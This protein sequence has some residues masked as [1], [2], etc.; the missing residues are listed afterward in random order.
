MKTAGNTVAVTD[1]VARRWQ[2]PCRGVIVLHNGPLTSR[3]Q[4]WVAL[5][6]SARGAALGGLTA[7]YFDDFEGFGRSSIEM[8]DVV[9]PYGPTR[10]RSAIVQ[11]HW[12]TS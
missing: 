12:S 8:Y 4:A 5:L 1:P 11:P 7:L 9:L 3:Q 2:R 10:P 6:T